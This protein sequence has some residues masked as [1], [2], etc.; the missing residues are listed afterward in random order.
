MSPNLA[1]L[2]KDFDGDLPAS[3]NRILTHELVMGALDGATPRLQRVL[4]AARR[5]A[6]DRGHAHVGCEHVFLAILQDQHS[7]PAQILEAAGALEETSRKVQHL[8]S[9]ESYARPSNP[10]EEVAGLESDNN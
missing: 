4:M 2:I 1:R 8:I 10:V 5:I 3:A 7:I 6:R 9:S